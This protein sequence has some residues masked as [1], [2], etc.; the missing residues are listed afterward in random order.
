MRTQPV[1][2]QGLE[3]IF[4]ISAIIGRMIR[5]VASSLAINPKRR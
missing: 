2:H 1:T 3:R 4:L 5:T